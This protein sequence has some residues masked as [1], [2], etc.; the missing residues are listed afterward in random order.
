M[1]KPFTEGSGYHIDS[2]YVLRPRKNLDEYHQARERIL[3]VKEM[4]IQDAQAT[5]C[6]HLQRLF[7]EFFVEIHA[8]SEVNQNE[9]Q[10]REAS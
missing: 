8:V 6:A 7:E 3:E 4:R 2:A 1:E 9:Q 5:C 10:N